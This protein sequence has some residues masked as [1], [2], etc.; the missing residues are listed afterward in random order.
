MAKFK[1]SP[2]KFNLIPAGTYKCLLGETEEGVTDGGTEFIQVE[3]RFFSETTGTLKRA[4][5]EKFYTTEAAMWRLDSLAEAA[6]IVEDDS[7]DTEY[8]TGKWVKTTLEHV[9]NGDYVNMN[10]K[11]FKK[12]DNP[13]TI[14]YDDSDI[15]F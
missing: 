5:N 8:L 15:P 14:G 4:H 10:L 13:P 12:L 7:Y 1:L 3:F 6:G 9:E 11:K 2:K